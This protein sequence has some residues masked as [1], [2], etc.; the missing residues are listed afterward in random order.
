MITSG[1]VLCAELESKANFLSA[2]ER[3]LR[4]LAQSHHC[5]ARPEAELELSRVREQIAAAYV[6]MRQFHPNA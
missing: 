3:S 6:Q 4:H 5:S 2:R 1:D